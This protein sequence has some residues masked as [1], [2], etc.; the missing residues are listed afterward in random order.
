MLVRFGRLYQLLMFQKCF[1]I[2]FLELDNNILTD[3]I[4]FRPVVLSEENQL[5]NIIFS[6]PNPHFNPKLQLFSFIDFP[7]WV[8]IK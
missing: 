5:K 4:A 7:S 1:L 6:N 3:W 2:L 8:C